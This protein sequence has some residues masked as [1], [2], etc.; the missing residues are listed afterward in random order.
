MQQGAGQGQALPLAAGKI[1][2]ALVQ[3]GVQPVF[4]AQEVRQPHLLQH[5]PQGVV[6]RRGRG[7]AQVLGHRA[8]EQ[9]AAQADQRYI[10]EQ[11][12]FLHGG[13][14]LPAQGHAAGIARGAAGQ[15]SCDGR[16]A[17]AAL[18]HQGGE[19]AA[20]EVEIQAVQRL[21]FVSIAKVQ[22]TAVDGTISI[23]LGGLA[24][25]FGQVQQL[26]D[27]IAGGHAVHSYMEVGPQRAHG[28]EEIRRQQQD[29]ERAAQADMTDRQLPRGDTDAQRRTA[30]GDDVHHNDGVQLHGQHLHRHFAEVLGLAVHGLVAGFVGLVDLQGGQALQVFK[31]AIAQG[32]ILAPVFAQQPL[33]KFLHSHDGN[34]DQRHADHQDDRCLYADRGQHHK[35]GDRCQH[36]VEK[37]RQVRAKVGLQLLDAFACQ[38]QYLGGGHSLGVAAAQAQ[39]FF[40]NRTAQRLFYSAAGVVAG[41]SR[42]AGAGG[43]HQ[44]R[45][46]HDAQR[47]GQVGGTGHRVADGQLVVQ[48]S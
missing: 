31:E 22:V 29:A 40:V 46:R 15:H 39:Q 37:L 13:K 28:Q 16:F 19:T 2:A 43:T 36:G 24:G 12:G 25:G 38:L 34:R 11:G 1:A 42:A 18:A 5:S 23:R 17:A 7:H 44:Q 47:Q 33:G 48:G 3:L 6:V 14:L 35:Q 10:F 8:F 26:K 27:L 30:V 4:A 21:F 45:R 32:G 9:V 20:G 41:R